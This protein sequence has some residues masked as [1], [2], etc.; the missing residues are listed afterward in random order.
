MTADVVIVGGGP[1]GLAAAI[2]LGQRGV[3]VLLC[4]PRPGADKVCGEGVMPS[5]VRA[6]EHLGVR[7]DQAQPLR[8]VRFISAGGAQAEACFR[9]GHGLVVRRPELARALY[10]ELERLPSVTLVGARATNFERSSGAIRVR[11]GGAVVEGRL[12]LGADG[13]S[14]AV[15]AWAGLGRARRT[16]RGRWGARQ[17]FAVAGWTDHVEV[18]FGAGL[19]AYVS[20]SGPEQ[21]GVAILWDS[22]RS[23]LGGGPL[24]VQRA[25][26]VFPA[27]ARRIGAVRPC[28]AQLAIGPLERR[29]R[30]RCSE[31]VLL[32]GDAAGYCDAIT[33]EG[34]SLALCSAARLAAAL[35]TPLA[36]ARAA[37]RVVSAAELGEVAAGDR[38]LRRRNQLVTRL[39]LRLSRHPAALERV[40]AA[41]SGEPAI[42]QHFLS[43]NMGLVSP[44]RLPPGAALRLVRA[45]FRDPGEAPAVA[46]V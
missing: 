33:G 43:A 18:Y 41:F 35:D 21:V 13:L 19:E 34:I 9:E 38:Q 31:G 14:S 4:E 27:L 17:H 8:G 36:R 11:A 5:G 40:L 46:S 23:T 22:A 7:F 12:L 24:L 20:C 15:R 44:L 45:L 26:K 37:G 6:L 32:V 30:A 16:A 25:I 39:L 42:F 29:T 10:A 2:A 1:A 28:S 3:R